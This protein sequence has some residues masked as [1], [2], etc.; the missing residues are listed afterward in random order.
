MSPVSPVFHAVVTVSIGLLKYS[1]H[2]NKR[3]STGCCQNVRVR[4][5]R[6]EHERNNFDFACVGG[7]ERNFL[8]R[9]GL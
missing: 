3:V 9:S 5:K 1:Q 2:L 6:G 7:R 4:E 8:I